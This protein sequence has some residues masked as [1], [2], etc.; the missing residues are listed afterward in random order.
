MTVNRNPR[1]NCAKS[2]NLRKLKKLSDLGGH[3]N[4]FRDLFLPILFH[5]AHHGSL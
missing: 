2:Y 5:Q 4:F 1:E 3:L